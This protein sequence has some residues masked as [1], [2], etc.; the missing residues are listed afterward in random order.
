MDGD[1]APDLAPLPEDWQRGLAIVAH[2]DDLEYG[3]ASAVARWTGQGK[4]VAYVLATEG[5][6]GIDGMLPAA[7]G[8]LRRAEEVR[9]AAVVGVQTV[10]FLDHRDGVVEYGLELRCDLA[11]MIRRH[12]PE[13][14]I[15][16]NYD[17]RW[18]WGGVNMADHRAVGLAAIDA[19]R[20]A[21]NRWVFPELLDEGLEPWGGVRR[22]FVNASPRAAHAVDVTDTLDRGVASLREHQVYL[23]G[24]GESGMADPDTFLRGAAAGTGTRFGGRPAVAFELLEL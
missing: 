24:L 11:R 9:G 5:E 7:A 16:S 15:L 6:A 22:V 19:A 23:E 21:G 20:D 1:A 14:L 10:E 2:P 4:E 13:V 18:P 8:P 3:A 17:E 12:R